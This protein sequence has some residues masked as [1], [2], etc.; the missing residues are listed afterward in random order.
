MGTIE[1]NKTPDLSEE[2]IKLKVIKNQLN[3]KYEKLLKNFN[4]L[5]TLIE[6]N[7]KVSAKNFESLEIML[8]NKIDKT[9]F[10]VIDKEFKKLELLKRTVDSKAD[11]E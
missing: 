5:D 3:N 10:N 11:H 8:N 7:F 6:K 4:D 2:F 1:I 9:E